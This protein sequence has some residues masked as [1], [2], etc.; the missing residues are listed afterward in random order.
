[1]RDLPTFRK[2]SFLKLLFVFLILSSCASLK[3]IEKSSKEKPSWLYGIETNFL[4]GEGKGSDYNEAKYNALQMVKEKIVASVAQSIS[5]EQNI[6]VN[7]TRYK[8]AIEFLEEYTSKTVSKTGSRSYLQGISLSKATD[9]YWEKKRENRIEEINY[10]I[11]YPFTQKDIDVLIKEWENQEEE[12]SQR[13]DTLKFNKNGHKTVE[14]IIAEIEELQYLS[15]FFVDQRKAT[16]D[17]SIKNLENKLNAI[18]LIPEVDSLGFFKYYLM[19]GEDS[20]K[21]MQKPKVNSNCADIKEIKTNDQFGCIKYE[22]DN[23]EVDEKNHLNI[24]YS[25]EEW[26]LKHLTHFDVSLKKIS[27]ENTNDINFSLVDKSLF[28]KEQTIKC[29]FTITS[30][31]PIPFTIDKVVLVP[32]LCKRNCN[33][34]YNFRNFP[35]IIIENINKSFSGKGNHSFEVYASIPK[36]KSNQ[37]ASRNGLSTKISGKVYY[38]SKETGE[39]KIH[40]FDNLEYFTNW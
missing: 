27:I 10:F 25:F 23:C 21:T 30:K 4:V 9:F 1:M 22:Y 36:S 16:A 24:A 8:K 32:K 39:S 34:D 29:Y 33:Y 15:S 17:I 26:N 28:K 13:L 7:E 5:F 35:V 6:E 18:Q 12:L 37:W 20:I 40:E 31:S 11:K 38:S 19:L 14:S 3:I 2:K